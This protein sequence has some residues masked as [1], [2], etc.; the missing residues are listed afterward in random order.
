MR[1]NPTPS[2]RG[3]LTGA[4]VALAAGGLTATGPVAL[5]ASPGSASPVLENYQNREPEL[6]LGDVLIAATAADSSLSFLIGAHCR[7]G[8]ADGCPLCLDAVGCLNNV[9][10]LIRAIEDEV[11]G[12]DDFISRYEAAKIT[13]TN[14]KLPPHEAALVSLYDLLDTLMDFTTEHCDSWECVDCR[15][16]DGMVYHVRLGLDLLRCD[17]AGGPKTFPAVSPRRLEFARRKMVRAREM[18]AE[19]GYFMPFTGDEHRSPE[20][21]AEALRERIDL[22]TKK[23]R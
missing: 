1:T 22:L 18:K 8:L 11:C 23:R 10:H 2:R 15:L 20:R 12:E 16:C 3:F 14:A 13:I 21:D 7:A 9:D 19:G 4:A 17:G 6:L 5:A